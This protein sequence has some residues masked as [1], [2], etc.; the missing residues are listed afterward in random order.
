MIKNKKALIVAIALMASFV[1]PDIASATSLTQAGVRLGRLGISATANNDV[2]VTFKL[3]TTPTSVAKIR[4]AFPVGFTITT[5]TPTIT[6]TGF[7]NTPA[8]IGVPPG[9]LTAV[10]TAGTRDIVVSGFTSA[11][12]NST[13]L[14]GFVIATGIVQNPASSGQ[15]NATVESQNGSSTL[16]DSTTT[17]VSIYGASSNQDQVTVSASVAPTFT[18]TLSANA[19]TVP[20]ADTSAIQTSAGV[21]L[22]VSTNSPLGYT[23]YVKSTSAAL[24]SATASATIPTGTFNASPDVVAAGTSSYTFV[25]S[26]GTLCTTGCGAAAVAYDGEYN[27]IDATHGGSFNSAGNFASFVSRPTYTGGDSFLLKERVAVSTIQPY[28]KDYTDTLTIVA[29]GNF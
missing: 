5:G 27:A 13:T 24:S 14:Y 10:S 9:T 1:L 22:S 18:F 7:P 6:T 4:V 29:A 28:A 19:D 16:I 2:L 11:S 12:L 25:P 17:P 23:A 8:S 21:T 20:Q 3:N 15:Y 26:S